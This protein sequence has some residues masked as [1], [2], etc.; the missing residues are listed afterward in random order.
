[1]GRVRNDDLVVYVAVGI[2]G[3]NCVTG[4]TFREVRGG[5]GIGP[6][7]GGGHLAGQLATGNATS[8]QCVCVFKLERWWPARRRVIFAFPLAR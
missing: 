6:R 3:A 8:G 1:M 4:D 5:S 7:R 2:A